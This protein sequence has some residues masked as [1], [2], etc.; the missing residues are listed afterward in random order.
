MCCSRTILQD[1]VD[2]SVLRVFR[3]SRKSDGLNVHGAKINGHNISIHVNTFQMKRS[4]REHYT[5]P[6]LACASFGSY[7]NKSVNNLR[8][9]LKFRHGLTKDNKPPLHQAGHDKGGNHPLEALKQFP[10]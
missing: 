8:K 10:R 4:N 3:H 1:L 5:P 7:R 6:L 2:T 9:Q